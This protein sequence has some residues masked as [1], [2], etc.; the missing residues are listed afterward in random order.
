MSIVKPA[1]V[2]AGA[3]LAAVII[4]VALG[5][6]MAGAIHVPQ[7]YSQLSPALASSTQESQD[8]YD[9]GYDYGIYDVKNDKE[10]SK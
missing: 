7:L 9:A 10:A 8:Y 5:A 1:L 2:G 6:V 4:A 3:S